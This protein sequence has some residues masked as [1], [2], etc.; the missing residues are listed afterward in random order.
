MTNSIQT[1]H[2]LGVEFARQLN[3]SPNEAQNW[4]QLEPRDDLPEEDYV[5]LRREFGEVTREMERAYR[6]GFNGTFTTPS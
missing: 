1:A 4:S 5:N 3:D 6:E 2:N